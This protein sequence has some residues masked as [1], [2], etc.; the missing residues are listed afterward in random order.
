VTVALERIFE[1]TEHMGQQIGTK[2][3]MKIEVS[4]ASVIG[5]LLLAGG[6]PETRVG[7]NRKRTYPTLA[8]VPHG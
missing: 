1:V 6:F 8:I 2:G 5:F 3:L 4:P 7:G